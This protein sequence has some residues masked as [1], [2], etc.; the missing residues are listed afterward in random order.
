M[1][2]IPPPT[3]FTLPTLI[4]EARALIK[5]SKGTT[6]AVILLFALAMILFISIATIG[7]IGDP[8]D[9]LPATP[10]PGLMNPGGLFTAVVS[11][12]LTSFFLPAF[13][14]I[15]LERSLG[16][17]ISFRGAMSYLRFAPHFFGLGLIGLLVQLVVTPLGGF[18]IDAASIGFGFVVQF[19]GYYIIGSGLGVLAAIGASARLVA[20]HLRPVLLLNL[21]FFVLTLLGVVTVGVAL[22]WVLPFMTI[23]SALV[24]RRVSEPTAA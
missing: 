1:S 10:P 2:T 20:L 3:P 17:P 12:V 22:I 9:P 7:A 18:A 11:I 4:T 8:A 5:G 16:L 15:G 6:F 24:Y 23:V 19:A 14:A 21:L 13:F